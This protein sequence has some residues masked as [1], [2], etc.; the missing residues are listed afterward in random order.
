MSVSSGVVEDMV[1][2]VVVVK[3]LV[4]EMLMFRM[5]VSRGSL[6]IM[7]EWKV[8]ISISR[9]ISSLMVLVRVML[10]MEIVNRLLLREVCELEG[11][12]VFRLVMIVCSVFFV[13]LEILVDLLLNCMCMMVV[14]L[15]LLIMFLIILL[16]G[17]VVVSML[18]RLFSLLIV[19]LMLFWYLVFVILLLLVVIMM[20]CVFVLFICGKECESCLRL[21]WDLVFGMENVLFVL[22]LSI[23]VL[24]FVML[25]VRSYDIRIC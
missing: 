10:G 17:E 4:I 13:F 20:N 6:V 15:L 21:V 19:F 18:L 23:R 5:V 16:Y 7:K 8:M 1:V 9:V 3:M 14:V 22:V 25:S 11:R 12:F 24:V 2:K